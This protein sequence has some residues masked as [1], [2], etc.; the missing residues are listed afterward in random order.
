[1]QDTV[2]ARKNHDI[3]LPFLCDDYALELVYN[4]RMNDTLEDDYDHYKTWLDFIKGKVFKCSESFINENDWTA[5][6]IDSLEGYFQACNLQEHKAHDTTGAGLAF[7]RSF[8]VFKEYLPSIYFMDAR[9]SLLQLK[10]M[11]L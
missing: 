1:M 10:M 7:E 5:R 6:F 4:E 3:L 9:M 11:F 8:Q 2:H